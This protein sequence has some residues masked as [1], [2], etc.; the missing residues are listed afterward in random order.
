MEAGRTEA[1][2]LRRLG[3]KVTYNFE[4]PALSEQDMKAKFLPPEY[5]CEG[6]AAAAFQLER[7]YAQRSV[8]KKL[9]SWE[10]AARSACT[11]R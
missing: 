6:C 10:V 11:V 2:L 4:P 3:K 8:K 7:A 9:A 1:Q 5:R